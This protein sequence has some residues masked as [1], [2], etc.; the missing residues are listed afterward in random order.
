AKAENSIFSQVQK[1]YSAGR[2]SEALAQ[3]AMVQPSAIS[4]YYSGLCYQGLNQLQLARREFAMALLGCK[5]PKLKKNSETA[6]AY[7]N[8]YSATR[9]YKG[10]GNNFLRPVERNVPG[11]PGGA[12]QNCPSPSPMDNRSYN[13]G[14]SNPNNT[15]FN[16]TSRLY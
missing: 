14:F 11:E 9:T 16:D 4:H 13:P 6:I 12:P 2:Y 7:L 3:L 8:H 5:D 10:Q 15:S 1:S